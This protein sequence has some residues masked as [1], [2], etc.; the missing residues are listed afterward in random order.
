MLMQSVSTSISTLVFLLFRH[1]SYVDGPRPFMLL[2]LLSISV[3]LLNIVWM[4]SR[5]GNECRRW[6]AV[7]MCSL[8]IQ[9][10]VQVS[11][12]WL[13]SEQVVEK[14]KNG[15]VTG[16]EEQTNIYRLY[17]VKVWFKNWIRVGYDY[18]YS[19]CSIS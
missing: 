13:G 18:K 17:S 7:W 10:Q 1:S 12:E 5:K 4:H 14:I 6:I 2:P 3:V 19:L 8:C 15:A 16:I 11:V 9:V